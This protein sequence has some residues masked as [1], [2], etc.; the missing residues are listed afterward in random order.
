M[1]PIRLADAR[2]N[3]PV[4][5]AATIL[6]RFPPG[7]LSEVEAAWSPARR[8]LVAAHQSAGSDLESSHWNWAGKAERAERGELTLFAVECEGAVQGLMAVP[9]RPRSSMLAPGRSG[10]YVDYLEAA[11][12]NQR[13]PGHPPRFV[14]VGTVLVAEAVVVSDELG[15][16]G[17]VGLHSLPQAEPFYERKCAM[18]RVGPDPGYY[19]LTYFEYAEGEAAAWLAGARATR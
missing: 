4:V 9:A 5:I 10:L 15:L 13:A 8:E 6:R 12:W 19:D 17:G 3:P 1:R 7:R 2:V 18:R 16:G 14:G 11:P